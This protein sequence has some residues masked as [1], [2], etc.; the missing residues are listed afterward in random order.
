MTVTAATAAP[1]RS[2]RWPRWLSSSAFARFLTAATPS[3]YVVLLLI[4]PV[5]LIGLYSFG[6]RSN[7]AAGSATGFS[8]ANWND[9]LT[10]AGNPFRAR[11]VTSML[12]TLGVSGM[13]V[14]G[15]YPLAY[16]LAFVARR[17]R[18]TIL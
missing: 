18:Y 9:F 2:R 16:F 17:H 11:F 6:L 14:I 4:V 3:L 8:T 13:A 1:R 7:P 5:V 12:V 10:G 15:A